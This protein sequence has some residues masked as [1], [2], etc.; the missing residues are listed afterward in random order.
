M[1]LRSILPKVGQ[2]HTR[3]VDIVA[4]Q[5]QLFWLNGK[6][7][8]IAAHATL[9]VKVLGC[10]G[11]CSTKRSVHLGQPPQQNCGSPTDRRDAVS[12]LL[13]WVDGVSKL[14]DNRLPA[15]YIAGIVVTM[16]NVASAAGVSTVSVSRALSGSR[17]V[18]AETVCRCK[19]RCCQLELLGQ[20]GRERVARQGD[21]KLWG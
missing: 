21:T 6:R 9:T 11:V 2:R 20:L 10:L 12:S 16:S 3:L 7:L 8:P 17:E 15:R 14:F 1:S 5:T 19:G 13:T 18:R 4:P